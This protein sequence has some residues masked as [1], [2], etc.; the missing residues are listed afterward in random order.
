MNGSLIPFIDKNLLGNPDFLT[1]LALHN[2]CQMC[3]AVH[4]HCE[5]NVAF[6]CVS[7]GKLKL[8]LLHSN[9]IFLQ[10]LHSKENDLMENSINNL[11]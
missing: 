3:L 5:V 11:G 6:R 9:R 1:L 2:F 7:S 4:L 8:K 10:Q